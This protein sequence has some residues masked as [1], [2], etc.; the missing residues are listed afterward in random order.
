MTEIAIYLV[1]WG[2]FVVSFITV[3]RV[4][5]AIQIERIFKKYRL[6]EINAAYFIISIL[7]SYLLAKFLIDIIE[8]FPLK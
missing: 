2:V 6:F 5:Q 4:L 8:L 7:T 1:F 3:F